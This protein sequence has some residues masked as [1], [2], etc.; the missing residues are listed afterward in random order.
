MDP[1]MYSLEE[2]VHSFGSR[3][4]FKTGKCVPK[5]VG[6]HVFEMLSRAREDSG[7]R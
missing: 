5:K 6:L 7:S 1:R 4:P 2:R 3:W